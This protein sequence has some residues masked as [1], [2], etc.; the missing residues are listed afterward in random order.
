M[1]QH[2]SGHCFFFQVDE[3]LIFGGKFHLRVC[4]RCCQL[5]M[6]GLY[7]G[8]WNRLLE[9][10][11]LLLSD[12]YSIKSATSRPLRA[13]REISEF[14]QSLSGVGFFSL[15]LRCSLSHHIHQDL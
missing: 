6:L 10:K 3:I 12:I 14:P 15:G 11:P 8:K 1:A 2:V 5:G 7:V 13:V 4:R 9:F